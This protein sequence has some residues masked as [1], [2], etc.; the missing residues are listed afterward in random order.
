MKLVSGFRCWP[1]RKRNIIITSY[2]D[3]ISYTTEAQST[4][5]TT[6]M[7]RKVSLCA[8]VEFLCLC[9][10]R[11]MIKMTS[12]ILAGGKGAR[13]RPDKAFVQIEG[14]PLIARQI[15]LLKELSTEII[16]V[17]NVRELYQGLAVRV[18]S[19]LVKD[20]GPL[21]GIYS[22]LL[23]SGNFYNFVCACDMPYLNLG[24]IKYMMSQIKGHDVVIPKVDDKYEPLFAIYSKRCISP[25]EMA[26]KGNRLRIIHI[27]PSVK[28][29]EIND[30]EVARF[31]KDGCAFFN[32]NTEKEYKELIQHER[33][34]VCRV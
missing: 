18:V 22:G 20:R 8:S 33:G 29:R 9:G 16:V 6:E 10:V 1:D 31:D 23:A 4:H 7:C 19:D 5:R 28:V 32:I 21:A 26:I 27:F 25:I 2:A 3:T 30:E 17:A 24:L 12:I 14:E 34:E 13:F 11:Y 15:R